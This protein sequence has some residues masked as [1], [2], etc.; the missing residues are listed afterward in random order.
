LESGTGGT[1]AAAR[2]RQNEQL[3]SEK[4]VLLARARFLQSVFRSSFLPAFWRREQ[5]V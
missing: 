4:P 1:G 5:W 2:G 3:Y